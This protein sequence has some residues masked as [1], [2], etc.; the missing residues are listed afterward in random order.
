MSVSSRDYARHRETSYRR[1]NCKPPNTY[2]VQRPLLNDIPC[3][4]FGQYYS[5]LHFHHTTCCNLPYAFPFSPYL[6]VILST[7]RLNC[8]WRTYHNGD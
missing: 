2:R 6:N 1:S 5:S 8:F 3:L 4:L 7:G